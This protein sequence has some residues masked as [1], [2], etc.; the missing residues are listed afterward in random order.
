MISITRPPC[1]N[2]EAL[3]H[4]DYTDA[5]ISLIKAAHNKCMY[6]EGK[7]GADSYPQVEHIQPK[8]KYPELEFAWDNLG[9]SCQICNTNKGA[10][11]DVTKRFINPY[12]EDPSEFIYFEGEY[13][14][15]FENSERGEYTIKALD[16]S[17]TRLCEKRRKLLVDIV[18]IIE[19]LRHINNEY[20][21]QYLIEDLKEKAQDTEEY[22]LMVKT[23]LKSEGIIA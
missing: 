17:R 2:Q 23:L 6:C 8:S 22:S 4:G 12:Q 11:Y 1:P 15:A 19:T 13:V 9:I 14:F 21:K 18:R 3:T 10:K 20:Y 5:K 7:L 16:L